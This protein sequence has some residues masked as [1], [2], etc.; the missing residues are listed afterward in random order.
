MILEYRVNEMSVQAAW[1]K[2]LYDLVEE[3]NCKCKT[4]VDESYNYVYHQ[5]SRT[6]VIE[7]SGSATM[8]GWLKLRM[9]RYLHFISSHENN[10]DISA[11]MH[12]ESNALD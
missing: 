11:E 9:E 7:I 2:T 4:Y 6:R 1:L 5:F 8:L 12:D 3:L 10:V